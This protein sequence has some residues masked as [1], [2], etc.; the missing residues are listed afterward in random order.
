MPFGEYLPLAPLLNSIGIRQFVTAF[1]GWSAGEKRNIMQTPTTPPFLPLICYESI[2]SGAIFSG[3][4]DGAEERTQFMLNLTND[5]WFDNSIGPEQLFQ[6]A[7]LRAVEHGIPM[8]RVAN[9]G[10]SAI[11]GPTG[12][13]SFVMEPGET[14]VIDATLPN[15]L[16]PTFF[17]RY[18]NLAFL[19][20]LAA[21]LSL[22]ALTYPRRPRP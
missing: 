13:L 12:R 21:G 5:G 18:P 22:V 3:A 6:H 10:K 7:R 15:R 4:G 17:S 1:K 8:V 11:V 19:L 20:I 14:G 16:A 9:T 2:F